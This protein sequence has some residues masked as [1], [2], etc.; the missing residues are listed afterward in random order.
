MICR[1]EAALPSGPIAGFRRH[2]RTA[3]MAFSSKPRP[4]PF[5]TCTSVT[6][7]VRRD[8][9]DQFHDALNLHLHRFVAIVGSRAIE[10]SRRSI[11]A[12]SRV[13]GA[14][15]GAV[16][17]AGTDTVAISV[18]HATAVPGAHRIIHGATEGIAPVRQ[19]CCWADVYRD[20]PR[21]L[22]S[23]QF[24]GAPMGAPSAARAVCHENFGN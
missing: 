4:S 12:R 18:A 23:S 22:A 20:C 21:P 3:S 10:A 2:V 16:T 7:A 9:S 17:F 19:A 8:H 6:R 1:T 5:A 11:S 15:A 14:A 13:R 24:P